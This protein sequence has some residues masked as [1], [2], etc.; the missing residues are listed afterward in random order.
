MSHR[1][2]IT[3]PIATWPKQVDREGRTIPV[4]VGAAWAVWGPRGSGQPL[5]MR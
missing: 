1:R 3:L 4:G 2:D 5:V